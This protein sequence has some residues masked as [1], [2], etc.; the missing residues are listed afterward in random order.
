VKKNVQWEIIASLKNYLHQAEQ[1]ER[2]R[3]LRDKITV[4]Y[5]DLSKRK[6]IQETRYNVKSKLIRNQ[7]GSLYTSR[8]NY[9][10][11]CGLVSDLHKPCITTEI[12]VVFSA[13]LHHLS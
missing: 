2:Q 9:F 8:R 7:F 4:I 1:L 13:L 11:Y 12:P 5:G 3:L 6:D 10:R